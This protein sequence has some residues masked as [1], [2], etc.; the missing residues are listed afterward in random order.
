[1]RE[2]EVG[3]R[4]RERGKEGETGMGWLNVNTAC[5]FVVR[6]LVDFSSPATE[7]VE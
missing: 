5:P 2:E 7:G 4:E 6:F 1:M 3:R